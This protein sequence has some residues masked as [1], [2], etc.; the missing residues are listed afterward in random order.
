MN[1][2]IHQRSGF[3]YFFYGL[4]LAVTPGIRQFVLL[5]LLAN[6]LLVGGALFYLFSHLDVWIEQLMGQLPGFLSWLS[7]ILW[8]LI[9]LTILATFS[10]FFSTL[11]NFVAAPFNGLLAEKVEEHLTGKKVNEDGMFAVVRDTPRILA[12]EWR[13]LL[14]VLPKAIGLF[15]LLLIPALGQTLGPVLWFGFTAWMLAIQ[16]CDYPFDN[17]KVPFNEM[18][19]NLK[20]KQGKAYSFGALVAIF[21]TVPILNLIIMPVAVC[22]ATAIWVSE[23]KR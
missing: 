15:I 8:P 20:Q 2:K 11:A 4:E 6:I 19:N 22:G 12:R 13:K 9:V 23:F 17:H 10:Y 1:S 14:Y 7:Y 3:G 21:T 16:Y 5:P 18:R